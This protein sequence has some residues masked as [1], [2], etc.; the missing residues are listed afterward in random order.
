MREQSNV[1]QIDM[2]LRIYK[3][4]KETDY[5]GLCE[6]LFFQDNLVIC[7]HVGAAYMLQDVFVHVNKYFWQDAWYAFV[8]YCA[9]DAIQYA[10]K[11][12]VITRDDVYTG[13]SKIE[14]AIQKSTHIALKKKMKMLQTVSRN[15]VVLGSVEGCVTYTIPIHLPSIDPYI[16]DHGHIQPLSAVDE[17][18]VYDSQGIHLAQDKQVEITLI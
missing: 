14:H 15:D 1:A 9:A 11:K 12:G 17:H 10:W 16:L 6:Q 3:L 13:V 4:L 5:Y 7:K 18:A 2:H 8:Y